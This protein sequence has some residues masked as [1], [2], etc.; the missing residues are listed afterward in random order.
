MSYSKFENGP[1]GALVSVEF[2]L[3]QYA[4]K[5]RKYTIKNLKKLKIYLG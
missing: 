2:K 4:E 5:A 3:M 1:C